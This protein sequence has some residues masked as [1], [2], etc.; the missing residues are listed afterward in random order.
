MVAVGVVNATLTA[1]VISWRGRPDN[2]V[3]VGV[4][5]ATLTAEVISWRGR[6]DNVVAVGVVNATL[7]AEV[8]SWRGRPDNVVAVGVV[9][10]TLTAEVISWRGRPDNV[11]AVG[12]DPKNSSSAAGGALNHCA[13]DFY[14]LLAATREYHGIY[15]HIG[16][17]SYF[18]VGGGGDL[19]FGQ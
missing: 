6:P 7:T 2:V 16:E 3:A 17:G 15:I 10:A 18:K 8:I 13:T 5:N 14:L 12:F 9:N 4:V 19:K 11:V 1:E